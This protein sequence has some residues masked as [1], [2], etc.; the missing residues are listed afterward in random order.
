MTSDAGPVEGAAARMPCGPGRRPVPVTMGS[1]RFRSAEAGG[2]RVTE[3]W[4]PPGAWL[5]WH[6]HERPVVAAMLAGSFDLSFPARTRAC[7]PG[8]VFSEP[9]GE[10]HANRIEQAG[11]HV[12]VLEPDPAR[13]ELLRPC[14][15]VLDRPCHLLDRGVTDLAR[16]AARELREDDAAAPLALEGL[17]LEILARAARSGRP[18]ER[19]RPPPA[20]L[21]RARELL[22]DRFRERL[23]MDD[24]AREAGVHP[25]HLARTFRLHHGSSVGAYVRG[26][27]LDWAA[28]RLL[29]SRDTLAAIALS[30]G[31]ADQSHFTRA[32][33]RH[34][35]V[36][37]ARFRRTQG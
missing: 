14:A 10:R 11:A 25:V 8:T 31:F 33:R 37:P 12:L 18:S 2:L 29:E 13:G 26:L 6:V 1:P 16:R 17:A 5:P 20:W 30:A 34:T 4:F 36:T 24:V 22:Q 28:A 15:R 35:G 21:G 19:R 27:R 3:A 23:R 7:P 32:F 9:A